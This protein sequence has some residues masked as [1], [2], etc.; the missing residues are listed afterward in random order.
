MQ[1]KKETRIY[2]YLS[3]ITVGGSQKPTQY[4]VS[5]TETAKRAESLKRRNGETCPKFFFGHFSAFL[6]R[7]F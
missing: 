6:I 1:A 4:T 3:A 7:F 2:L 5:N